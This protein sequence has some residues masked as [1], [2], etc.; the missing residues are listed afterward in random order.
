MIAEIKDLSTPAR[1]KIIY[2]YREK[3]MKH[4][5]SLRAQIATRKTAEYFDITT[6]TVYNAVQYVRSNKKGATE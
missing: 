1:H 6:M 3:L 5:T 2:K 4:P